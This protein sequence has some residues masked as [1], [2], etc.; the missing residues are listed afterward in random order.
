LK[1][2]QTTENDRLLQFRT[3]AS[4]WSEIWESWIRVKKFGFS[5]KIPEKFGFSQ[6]IPQAKIDFSGQFPKNV[7]FL[8]EISQ[9]MSIFQ[10]KFPKNFDFSSNFTK[11]S[12]LQAKI[13]YLQLFLDKLF[14]FSS[15]VTMALSNILLV[16]DKI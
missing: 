16:H 13:V 5:L 9:K 3:A 12:I 7:D 8:Q 14:Y 4:N 11:K 2:G 1:V 15:K 10:G 6:V